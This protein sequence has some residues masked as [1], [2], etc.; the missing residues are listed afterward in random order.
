MKEKPPMTRF[1]SLVAKCLESYHNSV[2]D[3]AQVPN[4][5]EPKL[6]YDSSWSKAKKEASGY[7]PKDNPYLNPNSDVYNKIPRPQ[8]KNSS[9][10]LF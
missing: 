9:N 6:V 1:N 2:K 5:S 10:A 4:P 3:K 7:E 8:K